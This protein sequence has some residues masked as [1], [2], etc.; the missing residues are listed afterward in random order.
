MIDISLVLVLLD[1]V[2]SAD[3]PTIRV[4]V[5][6]LIVCNT[7]SDALR[8]AIAPFCLICLFTESARVSV[9][10]SGNIPSREA[11]NRGNIFEAFARLSH[12]FLCFS[13]LEPICRHLESTWSGTSKGAWLQAS[14]FLVAS[15][16]SLPRGAPWT[17]AVPFFVGAPW[18]IIVLQAMSDGRGSCS[19]AANES[20]MASLLCPSMC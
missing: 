4:F 5:S 9:R 6:A 7:N 3:P 15:T 20:A 10:P 16:S 13:P 8:V 18:P 1:P 2:R 19:A 11:S 17:D 12:S 14:S